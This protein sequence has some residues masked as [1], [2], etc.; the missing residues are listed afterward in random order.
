LSRYTIRAAALIGVQAAAGRAYRRALGFRPA[1]LAKHRLGFRIG[2]AEDVG[3]A[4]RLGRAGKKEVLCNLRYPSCF[5]GIPY[6]S[7]LAFS[8]E[9]L[10]IPQITNVE[11][12]LW[13]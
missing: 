10:H 7:A 5:S 1:H 2:H 4:E 11:R 3:E 8:I 13:G 9:I 6:L 12:R